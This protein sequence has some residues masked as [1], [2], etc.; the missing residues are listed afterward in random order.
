[1]SREY[2]RSVQAPTGVMQARDLDPGD[3]LFIRVPGSRAMRVQT[4]VNT[5]RVH[6][7]V[8]LA[9]DDGTTRLL[10]PHMPVRLA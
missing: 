5:A 9:L 3:K 2:A 1:M 4:I 7:D 6:G 10:S 8:A